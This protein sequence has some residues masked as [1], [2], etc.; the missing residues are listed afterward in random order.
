[1]LESRHLHHLLIV[2]KHASEYQRLMVEADLPE[3]KISSTDLHNPN[4]LA[5]VIK[6]GA[7]FDLGFGEP[8]LI[9]Q[10]LP[11]LPT[12]HWVQ[13][14][15]AGV[16]PLL[17]PGLRRDYTLTN[18][19]GVFGPLMSEFV[20][21]YLLQHERRIIARFLSQQTRQ[22]D[23]SPPGTLRGKRLGL[24]GIGSI[25]AHLA[26]TAKHFGMLVSGYTR[27]REDCRDVDAYFHS[28]QRLDFASDLDYLVCVLPGTQDTRHLVDG[29]LL[30]RLPSHA[31]LINVGRGG[32]IDET[33]LA[34]ALQ[35]NRLAGAV[36]DVFQQEP[37]PPE[38]VFWH[39]PNL[40]VTAHTAAPSFPTD[41]AGLFIKNYQR[42]LAGKPL[43]N[44]VNFERGY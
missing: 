6:K 10:V 8:N 24:M 27:S 41:I 40:L 35:A 37:L 19:R 18:V 5:Q 9:V 17:A 44:Q 26:N 31:L 33:A 43:Q 12:L 39:T 2:S 21:G 15:W 13:A 28:N 22:W 20:F 38:H 32:V 42:L 23:A 14:T 16:E 7:T 3:L 4:D 25:G 11:Y 1:M 29:A 36:L 30:G 34:A